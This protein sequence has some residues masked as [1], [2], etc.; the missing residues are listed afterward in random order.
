MD[1]DLNIS[2]A[3][4]VLFAFV[5]K[6]SIPLAQG[7]LTA[8]QRDAVLDVMKKIDGVLGVMDFEEEQIGEEALR[9]MNRRDALRQARQWAEADEIRQKLLDMGIIVADTSEG[10][11]WH[12]K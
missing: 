9:L 4:A 1:D 8:A 5:K 10:M 6:V 2:G 11:V 3:L 7:V 12:L